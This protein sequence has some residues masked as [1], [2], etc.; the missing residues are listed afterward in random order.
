MVGSHIDERREDLVVVEASRHAMEYWISY[1]LRAGV[2]ISAVIILAGGAAFL[3]L[4]PA[5]TEPHS[6][7][8]LKQGDYTIRASMSLI[9]RGLKHRRAT[10]VVDVGILALI[11]TP[12]LRVA[13]TVVLFFLQR[14][15]VFVGITA[16]VL[17][18]LLLGVT[19]TGV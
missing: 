10:A 3:I 17:S 1:V 4:G 9:V 19:G 13:M 6:I 8:Q 18:V 16:I 11:I 14:D 12:V 5:S 15:W 2:L 7:Q